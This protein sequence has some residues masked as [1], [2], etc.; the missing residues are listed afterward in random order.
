MDIKREIADEVV[1][2]GGGAKTEKIVEKTNCQY[3]DQID[4]QGMKIGF[5]FNELDEMGKLVNGYQR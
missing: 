1:D 2:L 4:E 5:V 3:R